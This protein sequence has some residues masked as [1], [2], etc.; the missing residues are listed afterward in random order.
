MIARQT[1]VANH[2]TS[3]A[4]RRHA[5]MTIKNNGNMGLGTTNPGQKLSVNGNIEVMNGNQIY[6]RT[7]TNGNLRGYI[8][9]SEGSPHL[10]IATSGG[11]DI[12]FRD[13]G[14]EHHQR[15]SMGR[16]AM[17]GLGRP[18]RMNA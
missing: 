6:L 18:R 15:S 2:T 4:D 3:T 16:T 7:G 14:P 11:E 9:A 13:G 8:R 12:A 17:L 5:L 10:D 1:G